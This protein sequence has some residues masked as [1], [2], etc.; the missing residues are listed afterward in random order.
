LKG[1]DGIPKFRVGE[2]GEL[3]SEE[4][5]LEFIEKQKQADAANEKGSEEEMVDKHDEL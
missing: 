1:P 5:I 4:E 2:D 3:P